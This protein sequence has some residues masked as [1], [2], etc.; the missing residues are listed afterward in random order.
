MC[1]VNEK[2]VL[3]TFILRYK[4]ALDHIDWLPHNLLCNLFKSMNCYCLDEREVM[5]PL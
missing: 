5:C 4:T 3:F 1:N 2:E